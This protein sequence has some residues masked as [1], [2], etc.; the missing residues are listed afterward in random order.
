MISK[1]LC[2][3]WSSSSLWVCILTATLCPL[4]LCLSG[5]LLPYPQASNSNRRAQFVVPNGKSCCTWACEKNP[6]F[7]S[8][9]SAG[10]PTDSPRVLQGGSEHLLRAV[11]LS[12]FRVPLP[13]SSWIVDVL[14]VLPSL[15]TRGYYNLHS[16][17]TF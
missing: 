10:H 11:L 4:F 16:Q 3:L 17:R 8:A 2:S 13:P 5:L 15:L 1:V 9:P 14:L 7:S 6:R 12:F